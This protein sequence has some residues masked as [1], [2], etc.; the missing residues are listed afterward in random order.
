MLAS[1]PVTAGQVLI[2]YNILQA[3]WMLGRMLGEMNGGEKGRGLE[4]CRGE[5]METGKDG[6]EKGGIQGMMEQKREGDREG[7]SGTRE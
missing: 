5:G 3:E 1:Q 6:E 7:W 4:G 2:E